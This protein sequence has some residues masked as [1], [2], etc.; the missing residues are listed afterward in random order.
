MFEFSKHEPSSSSYYYKAGPSSMCKYHAHY[1]L[2]EDIVNY[3]IGQ[4]FKLG[5]WAHHHY[6]QYNDVYDFYDFY[7]Q[8]KDLEALN[9]NV[10]QADIYN[11]FKNKGFKVEKQGSSDSYFRV[12]VYPKEE[13][14]INNQSN[15]K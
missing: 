10:T 8:V 14:V 7:F 2:K 12:W 4:G 9:S 11:H 1:K 3:L 15:L 13:L 5:S 6:V